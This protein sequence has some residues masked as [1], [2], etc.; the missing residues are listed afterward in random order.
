MVL[1]ILAISDL[2]DEEVVLDR[3][4]VILST[5]AYDYLFIAGDVGGNYSYAEDLISILSKAKARGIYYVP[6]NNEDERI[7][8]LFEEFS[9]HEKRVELKEGLNLVG[10]GFSPPTPFS[11]PGEMEE[12]E[13]FRRMDAL[14]IDN[15]TIL[16]THS[17]PYGILDNV[18]L[19]H[20]GSKAIL[21]IVKRKKPFLHLFGHVH[22]VI[23]KE[24]HYSTLF[25]NLPPAYSLRGM[26]I[27]IENKQG[28]KDITA[29]IVRL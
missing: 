27:V 23:G 25:I 5:N 18:E 21:E 4:R 9:V 13:M 3:L 15:N 22:E 2:H 19:L 24:K 8:A 6:G 12:E 7:R 17:P 14:A 20:V 11:T 10:F 26:R 1:K 16:L 28:L 29:E